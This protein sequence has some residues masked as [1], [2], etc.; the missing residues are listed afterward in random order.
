MKASV[1][2]IQNSLATK[3]VLTAFNEPIK[4]QKK[5]KWKPL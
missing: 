5:E 2:Q 4:E 1:Y 3:V